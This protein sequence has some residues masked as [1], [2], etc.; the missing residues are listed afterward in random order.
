MGSEAAGTPSCSACSAA[1]TEAE[2]LST[3]V[4]LLWINCIS[5]V[6]LVSGF[7]AACAFFRA[8]GV[9]PEVAISLGKRLATERRAAAKAS[10]WIDFVHTV[11][12]A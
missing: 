1:G 5:G 6:A 9:A 8:V 4:E 2:A 3:E 7:C 10:L 11:N 12:A